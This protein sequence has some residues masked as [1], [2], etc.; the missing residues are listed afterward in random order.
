[1]NSTAA[2]CGKSS[3]SVARRWRYSSVPAVEAALAD[4]HAMRNAEQFGVGELDP[5]TGIAIVV[6]YVDAGGAELGI[7]RLGRRAHR[8]A[9][10]AD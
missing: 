10:S 4:D 5:G 8:A 6:Q 9:T 7:E 3:L 2:C 1:M